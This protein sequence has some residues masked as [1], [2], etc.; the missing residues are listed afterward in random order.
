SAHF[1][2]ERWRLAEP[3]T[4]GGDNLCRVVALLSGTVEIAGEGFCESWPPGTT[5]IL[6]ACSAYTLSPLKSPAVVLIGHL[7]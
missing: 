2:L 4:A 6:P 1:V 5:A 7:P 3:Q